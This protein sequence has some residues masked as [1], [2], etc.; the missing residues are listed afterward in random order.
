MIGAFAFANPAILL[1]LVALP[2]IWFLLRL[3]PP[4]PKREVFPPFAILA[5]VLQREETPATSPWWLTALRIGLATIIILAMAGPIYNPRENLLEGDGAVALMIDNDWASVGDWKRRVETAANLIAEAET[6]QRPVAIAFT[7]DPQND[8]VPGSAAKA[9]ERLNA[10]APR[11]LPANRQVALKSLATAFADS[12]PGTFAFVTSGIAGEDDEVTST[13]I[14]ALRPAQILLFSDVNK[15]VMAITGADNGA[16]AI[17]ISANRLSSAQ[18]ANIS[19]DALD[20]QGRAIASGDVKFAD[21]QTGAT[22]NVEAPFELR[23][24]FAQLALNT[25]RN[26]GSTWL[27]DDGFKRR[28][29][30]LLSGESRDQSQPLLSPLYYIRRAL[31][32]YAD[33]TEPASADLAEAVPSLLADKPS[34]VIM[35]DI[36]RLPEN[37][38]APLMD[39]IS[40]GGTLV[41]FAGPRLAASPSDDPLVPVR[42]RQGERSLTGAFS[43][44]AAQPLAPFKS[45]SPFAGL[46]F[47]DTVRINRQVL[48]EPS[49]EL[50]ANTWASLADGT[51]LVTGR[52]EGAGSI[53]LFHTSAEATWSNLP[54]SGNFV[55]MLRRIVQLSHSQGGAN[56][57]NAALPPYRLLSADGSLTTELGNAK[58]LT[59]IDGKLPAVSHDNPPG[60]YGSREGFVALNLFAHGGEITPLSL[61]GLSAPINQ[62]PLS[63]KQQ[64]Q[65][66]PWLLALALLLLVADS[67]IVMTMNGIFSAL[68]LRRAATT[69]LL[70]GIAVLLVAID[71]ATTLADDSRPGDEAI[72]A[73]L[74][75][76]H[77]AYV[78]TGEADVDR[79]S[80]AG[81]T[82]LSDYLT[83]RTALEPGEPRG[84][85]L[86]TDELALYPIIYWPITATAPLPSDTAINRVSAYMRAGGTV[87]FDTRD[88]YQSFGNAQAGANSERL[89]E[90]LSGLDIP[91]L[92]PVPATHVLTRAF[93][94]LRDFPGRYQGGSLW[95]E[96]S[97]DVATEE[98]GGPAAR[99][100][101]GVSSIII[102]SNDMAGAWAVDDQ[103][104]ALLPV[105]PSDSEQREMA[106]RSGVNIVM[107]MLTGNYKSDQVH[108]PALLERL[109]Q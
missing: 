8:A 58:A 1:A 2:A 32:P 89:Q 70:A 39:W 35:A 47:P 73:A 75:E 83:F 36:G 108:V 52:R 98:R 11:P 95:V 24:D 21:G 22:G 79:I 9:L 106:F 55:E 16:T 68:R 26:A 86:E 62:Q 56:L 50:E 85:D 97:S 41:R 66:S 33:L 69:A 6:A 102:T 61:T 91:P 13:A 53:V 101:D 18:A 30:G 54:I 77:L 67:V 38:Y 46:S 37:A 59:L 105:V 81:L 14:D 93:Y 51:P 72:F 40:K 60:L 74:N 20:I 12:A 15:P 4:R 31:A 44:S 63:G 29:V 25:E 88:Q 76:T 92:E 96:A 99:H 107:Y 65:L 94:L 82:G 48:A 84:L 10:A 42:L 80:L 57:P 90:I 7:A 45:D 100:S 19:V 87:L 5:K 28:R 103:G 104:Y 78:M 71:P 23:N 27:L 17:N 49:P 34:V 64:S 43:W 3:T 109:G